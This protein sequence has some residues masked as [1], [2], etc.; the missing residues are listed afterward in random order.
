MNL[1]YKPF[2][3][4]AQSL[5]ESSQHRVSL[6]INSISSSYLCSGNSESL[7]QHLRYSTVPACRIC[8]S[9]IL[10][11]TPPGEN[12][13]LPRCQ[14]SFGHHYIGLEAPVVPIPI[15]TRLRVT[16]ESHYCLPAMFRIHFQHSANHKIFRIV[17]WPRLQRGLRHCR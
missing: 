12:P 5:G 6:C 8:S 2:F 14:L 11:G 3:A 4:R 1:S 13:G 15:A 7:H 16:F 9:E 10:P 17:S